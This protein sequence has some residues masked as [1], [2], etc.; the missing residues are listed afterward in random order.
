M[1]FPEKAIPI[2][3]ALAEQIKPLVLE[4]MDQ[5]AAARLTVPDAGE[6]VLVGLLFQGG[7]IMAALEKASGKKF[8]PS[9]LSNV[10]KEALKCARAEVLKTKGGK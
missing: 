7:F 2:V 9:V 4:A 1:A 5:C 10:A 6:A 3:N 8:S